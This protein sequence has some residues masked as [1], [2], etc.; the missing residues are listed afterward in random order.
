[1]KRFAM[2]LALACLLSVSTLGGEIP[3]DFTPPP[4][5]PPAAIIA[6]S[7]AEIP[8]GG[9]SGQIPCDIAQQ[10]EDA[11]YAGFIAVVGWLV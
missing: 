3:C 4:P 1:M 6:T 9:I 11:A 2:A 10:A 8:S 5:P 7:P